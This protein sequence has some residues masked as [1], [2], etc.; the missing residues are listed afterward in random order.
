LA[1]IV[2]I[3]LCDAAL[4]AALFALLLHGVP[5]LNIVFVKISTW[6]ISGSLAWVKYL[7]S[8][9]WGYWFLER[10]SLGLLAAYYISVAM[11]LFCYKRIFQGKRFGMACLIS[12]WVIFSASFFTGSG[13]KKFELTMLASGRNQIVHA[14]F[15][16]EAHWL[17][18]AGRNFPSDQGEWLIAPFLRNRGAQRL[19]GILLSDLSKTNTGGL[20]SV[21]RDFP[22][23]Y[24][25]YPAASLYRPDEFY[26]NLQKLGR[27]AKTFQQ[28]DE[29]LMGTE[30]IRM[31]SQSEKGAAFLMESG[32]WRILFV[33]RWDSELFKE[34][35]SGYEDGKEIHAVFLPA[36][37]KRIPVEFQDWFDRVR[38]LLV[39]LPDLQQELASFF[40]SRHVPSLDLKHTGAL[41][42]RRNGSRLELVSFLKGPLGFYSYS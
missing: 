13:G 12:G 5:V 6:I 34:L 30:K 25:L 41:G 40:V 35:L 37:G 31:L 27:K 4:F 17:L 38:P 16:N 14:R 23:R 3:P 26:K 9:S 33:S 39:V 21:L 2:A 19:E 7:S 20:A 11:I 24:L 29:V 8:W 28:G 22:V 1:N 18:N 10:P 42:F 36:A 32:S 15:S